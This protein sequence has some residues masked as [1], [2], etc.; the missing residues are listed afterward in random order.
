MSAAAARQVLNHLRTGCPTRAPGRLVLLL[1]AAYTDDAGTVTLPMTDLHRLTGLA[2]PELEHALHRLTLVG[3][4]VRT[5]GGTLRLPELG[6]H[7][8]GA[9]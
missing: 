1:L 5:A 7:W 2:G 9:P 4:D 8:G 3:H 6:D